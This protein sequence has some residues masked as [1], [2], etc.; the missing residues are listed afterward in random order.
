MWICEKCNEELEDNFDTCWKCY[1]GSE[2][3]KEDLEVEK[4]VEEKI[5][6]EKVEEKRKKD[7]RFYL[8]FKSG[9][10]ALIVSFIALYLLTSSGF[11]IKSGPTGTVTI[12][13]LFSFYIIRGV[14]SNKND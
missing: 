1:D 13:F 8:N 7:E 11:V 14:L 3:Q 10:L 4:K 6:I 5:E 9:A 12:V 2:R